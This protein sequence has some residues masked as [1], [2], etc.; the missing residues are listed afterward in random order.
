MGYFPCRLYVSET[1]LRICT[2]FEYV[3]LVGAF[4]TSATVCGTLGIVIVY[5]IYVSKVRTLNHTI[6]TVFVILD[7]FKFMSSI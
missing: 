2:A 3:I 5:F 4:V 7:F 1:V 6:L